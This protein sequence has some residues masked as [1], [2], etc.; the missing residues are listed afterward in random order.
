M[1]DETDYYIDHKYISNQD[2]KEKQRN[3]SEQ[4]KNKNRRG[5]SMKNV[6]VQRKC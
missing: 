5:K 3:T 2:S 1:R 6:C 4:R